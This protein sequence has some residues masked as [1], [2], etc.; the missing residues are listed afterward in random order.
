M[1]KCGLGGIELVLLVMR[2]GNFSEVG[3]F[4]FFSVFLCFGSLDLGWQEF[5]MF[6]IQFLSDYLSIQV[7]GS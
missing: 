2:A 7:A 5:G 6:K 3:V 1:E 4:L